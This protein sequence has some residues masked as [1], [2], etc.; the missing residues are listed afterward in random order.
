MLSM[1]VIT[2]R[3]LVDFYEEHRDAKVALSDWHEKTRQAV[4]NNFAD[5]RRTF[6]SADYVGSD[7]I[8]FNIKGNDYR[9]IAMVV[10]RKKKVYI[11]FVGTHEAYDRIG[12]IEAI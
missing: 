2:K 3:K 8:V 9:L 10:Y 11:R 12:N 4:W 7:R 6:N 1:R 5:V